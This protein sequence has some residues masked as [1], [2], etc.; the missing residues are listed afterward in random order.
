M[1]GQGRPSLMAIVTL[2]VFAG[3]FRPAPVALR[4][5]AGLLLVIVALAHHPRIVSAEDHLFD[6]PV[7]IRIAWGGK[8][9][10]RWHGQIALDGGTLSDVQLL[11][12]EADAAASVWLDGEAIQI[13][14][15]SPHLFDGVDVTAAATAAARLT[16]ELAADAESAPVKADVPLDKALREPFR[17]PLD[18]RGN[19][20]LVQRAPGD[21]LRIVSGRDT[22]IFTPGEQFTF[23]VQPLLDG[24]DP[25]TTIDIDT[26]LTPARSFRTVWNHN[27][28]LPVPVEGPATATIRIP[29][30]RQEGVYDI[31]LSITRPPGF[32][33]RFLPGG[34][35]PT[36]AERTFQVVVLEP[37]PPLPASDATWQSV[38]EIDPAS[39]R[40]WERLPEWTRI[41]RIPGLARRPLGSQRSV[42]VPSLIGTLV[43]LPPTTTGSDPHW[44]AYSL[45]LQSVGTPHLLE[46]E[47][48]DDQEQHLGISIVEPNAAGRAV[49]I[50]RDS[51]VY[52]EGLGRSES[53]ESHKHR[54]VFWPRTNAPLLL[55]TN[56]HPSSSA[57]F[58][59]VR[60]MKRSVS[61]IATDAWPNTPPT[62]RLVAAYLSKPLLPETFGAT[63]GLD[64][65]SGHS[66]DDWA[67][68]Y[69][70]ATRLAE[71]LNYA[72][73]NS[74]AVSVMADGSCLFSSGHVLSTPLYNTSRMVAGASDLP[75]VDALELLLRVFDRSG[76][77]LVPT[78]QFATPLPEL[79]K[80]RRGQD[81]LSSG[82]E[83]VGP[84]GLTWLEVHGAER[85][86]AP[87][88]NLLDDQVQQAMLEVVRDLM[89]R[90]GHHRSMAGLAV[91]LSSRG[92]TVLPDLNW[93]LDDK[94]VTRFTK[95]TGTVLLDDG[96]NRFAARQT[97]LLGEH[98]DAWQEWRAARVTHF[99][100][101][102]AHLVQTSQPKRRLLLT[103]EDLFTNPSRAAEFRPS[104]IGRPRLDRA[105]LELG[106][107]REDL[108][109]TPGVLLCPTQ[110][111]E[112]MAPLVDRAV[113][114][115]LNEAF[116]AAPQPV[117]RP[118]AAAM[119]YYPPQRRRLASFDAQSPFET[120]T[121]LVSQTLADSAQARK[122]MATA[123][124]N[125]DPVVV[126][127]GGELLPMGQE[128]AMRQVLKIVEQ[129]PNDVTPHV[130]RADNVTIRVYDIGDGTTCL[131]VNEC[132][133][134][135]E[136][137]LDFVLPRA[138]TAETLGGADIANRSASKE[139]AAG[140]QSW[141]TSLAPYE[142]QALR[143]TA[144]GVELESI[145]ATISET[146]QRELAARVADLQARDLTATRTYSGLENP[147]FE[148]MGGGNPTG[149]W[150]LVGGGAGFTAEL[151]ATNPQEGKTSI[152]IRN[153]SDNVATLESNSFATPPTGELAVTLFVRSNVVDPKT[154][155][156]IVFEADS[157]TQTYR[158][159]AVVGGTQAGSPPLGSEWQPYGFS[160]KVP[161][162]SSGRMRMKLELVG[163]GEVW[164][165]QVQLYD[166]LF[167]LSFYP[168]SQ[169]EKLEL[170]K[171]RN[172]V[173]SARENGDYSQ[174]VQI[175]EGYWPRFLTAYTPASQPPIAEQPKV[176]GKEAPPAADNVPPTPS[177][178]ERWI[179][180]Y[181]PSILRR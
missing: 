11:G 177:F 157:G 89:E 85:G 121:R 42:A 68:F 7:R 97:F 19:E 22:L 143:F 28:R 155:L 64:A 140:P 113:D 123:F 117:D 144:G 90:Y 93:G 112:S 14:S 124:R 45:P 105:V 111:V 115:E 107:A 161:L 6:E 78:L 156:R 141:Q 88:Y 163:K 95:D 44:Q 171:L 55:V 83:L 73:Y 16:V 77:A 81:P 130:K 176:P 181:M 178:T 37:N 147:G 2:R 67:T 158:R 8:S 1:I 148:A 36:L 61:T 116:A 164:V 170:V 99:Y 39:P 82:L 174:C 179:K 168:H 159:F 9:A 15:R 162:D 169:Q 26:T 80:L 65:A 53:A 109:K 96:I 125:Q 56:L 167:P 71:Y 101:E 18:D 23:D 122:L 98:V 79:E 172:A 41:D 86:L 58:G 153:Q 131:V 94:T 180:P 10:D 137:Q 21:S 175:L 154:E 52:V 84:R 43:E 48:P 57:R 102:L 30:P 33:Q 59:H 38:L 60:V 69:E 74:A 114:L 20:L 4:S 150:I 49:P 119:F 54:L 70:S 139:F 51:G 138:A 151:D 31:R 129:L 134:Q 110:Y 5:L 91:Q 13:D 46:I 152:Y 27:Q 62:D 40:W 34:V 25:S 47:Y 146:G 32:R 165:D 120:H 127:Q 118:H 173:D 87:Y 29:L 132:P 17:L 133:W 166:L 66:V 106:I 135:T 100:S 76:L 72:G 103:T 63:E 126:L 92:Y 149:G 104:V 128:S 75:S 3:R 35:I 50:G 24:I 12:M 145:G 160:E 142:I 108:Q 136:A